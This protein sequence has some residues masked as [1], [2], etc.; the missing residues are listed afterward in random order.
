E[1]FPADLMDCVEVFH[2]ADVDIDAAD[3][4][5]GAAGG[6]DSGLEILA[7]LAGLGFD[8]A[9]T[10]NRSV[11]PS[12]G[13]SRNEDQ[14]A[15]GLH[16]CCLREMA[17][18]LPDP[19]A[20]DLLLRHGKD[21]AP[22]ELARDVNDAGSALMSAILSPTAALKRKSRVVRVGHIQTPHN[23]AQYRW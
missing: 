19:V 5:D 7:D 18:W 11:G 17:A 9:D 14:T 22:M 13:P 8:V 6:L 20:T 2:I 3:V 10:G 12:R 4:V 23:A 1:I 15:S 21:R 16:H